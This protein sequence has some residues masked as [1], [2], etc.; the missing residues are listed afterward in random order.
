MLELGLYERLITRRLHEL[1]RE[2]ES[3]GYAAG[4]A[5]LD[6]AESHQVLA[7]HVGAVLARRLRALPEEPLTERLRLCN[8][9]LALLEPQG[10][11]RVADAAQLLTELLERSRRPPMERPAIPLSRNDLLVAA[12]GEPSVGAEIQRELQ[13]ADRVDLLCAFVR[14]NG[15][16]ILREP[17]RQLGERGVRLRVITSTY[18]GATER[19]AL[20]ELVALGADVRVSYE[21]RTTRLHAKAW[22]FD[23]RTGYSTALVGSS[24]L[25]YSALQDGLEWNVRVAQADSP[26]VLAK[27][28]ATFE[29]YWNGD[30]FEPYDPHRDAARLDRALGA[31]TPLGPLD[32]SGLE[33][34]PW[35]Y[36]LEMLE[37]LD[38]E[39]ERHG[40]W[41]NLVLA[42]TG[43]GKTVV[44]ALDY[45][46]V[47]ER[48]GE[49]R[50]LFVAHR[51]EILEQSRRVFAEVLRDG[52]FGELLVDGA[53]PTAWRHVFASIQSLHALDVATL[54]PDRFDVVIVDEFHHAEADTYSRLLEHVRPKLLLGLTATP[55]RADGR[56]VL[57]W[58]GDRIAFEMRLWDAL[59]QALLSPFQY[60]GIADD[61]DLSGL[62]WSRGGYVAAELGAVYTGNDA[63][64]GKV[65]RAV[66]DLVADPGSMRALG[67]CVS[68]AHAQYMADVFRRAGIKAEAVSGTTSRKDRAGA[69]RRLRSREINALFAVDLFNE[70]LDVPEI[71]TVLF[72]RPTESATVFL[73]QLGRGLRL[74]EG[75][76]CL[77]VLDFIGAA[78]QRFRFD[79]RY[80]ALTG[81][82]RTE[83][84]RQTE[85]GFPFLPAGCHLALDQRSQE[86]VLRNVRQAVTANAATL[87]AELRAQGDTTLARFLA[88]TG[89]SLD[90]LYRVNRSWTGLRRAAGLPTPPEG[91]D[92]QRLLRAIGRSLHLGDPE[93]LNLYRGILRADLPP[94]IDGTDERDRRLLTMLH[95]QLWGTA[96]GPADLPS[97]LRRLWD[98]P[99]VRAE[100]VEVLDLLDQQA[101]A[102]TRPLGHDAELPL[103]LHA[104]YSRDEIIAAFGALRLDR[105]NPPR[106]GVWYHEPSDTDVFFVTLR[107]SQRDYS[108][109]T[110]YRDYAISPTLFHWESQSTTSRS[111]KTGQRY[112]RQAERKGRVLLFVRRDRQLR[113][114]LTAPYRCL[115]LAD[116][117]NA[118]GDRPISITWRL[119]TPMPRELFQ[120][121]KVA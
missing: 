64:A 19:R 68:V 71:D 67:F 85:Q 20:D 106:E 55:E 45:R 10:E 94:E 114:N 15:V 108:P 111:S 99:A 54:P 3:A 5:P 26:A 89:A 59:D 18:L 86:V 87:T 38:V 9:V 8:D 46:R 62:A 7:E 58:F 82:S 103:A 75:K 23:R 84:A 119:G 98:H 63:R 60:F 32:V 100:L 35:P 13:S 33:V 121:L 81:L 109:T 41:R 25:S 72:L 61:V 120:R 80:R 113:P 11:E 40:R 47:R 102:L 66:E 43:T 65:L 53:K 56:S 49:A 88:E 105:P 83:L 110:L 48:W 37:S 79:L 17:L 78:H 2:M 74:S 34:K 91:P 28:A 44:A 21:T 115:G 51:K 12:P 90:D 73:Q 29:G 14:W 104:D 39:R 77:T 50:L 69:L 117:V 96:N 16:R 4:R 57:H 95:F 116:F 27:F 22:L 92:E 76:S 42:P 6:A 112:L 118:T 24:N 97:S 70:G 36:Q 107:K 30:D 52:S 93:R 1:L 101:P 31:S